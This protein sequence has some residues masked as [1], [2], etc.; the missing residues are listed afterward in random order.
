MYAFIMSRFSRINPIRT[1]Y[2]VFMHVQYKYRHEVTCIL[3]T[4]AENDNNNSATAPLLACVAS[5][6]QAVTFTN[7]LCASIT[8][9]L[10]SQ[11]HIIWFP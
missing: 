6:V 4:R 3:K 11:S 7:D 5:L 1:S 2:E 10:V 9:H 8:Y